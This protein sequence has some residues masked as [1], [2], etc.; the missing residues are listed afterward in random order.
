MRKVLVN[1]N[2]QIAPADK[3]GISPLDRSFLFGDGIYETGR[4]LK[5]TFVF[6][7]DHLIRFRQSAAK[8]MIPVP[9]NNEFLIHQLQ[10]TAKRFGTDDLYFR[11]ILTR[12]TIDEVGLGI[13][14]TEDPNLVIIVQEL[15]KNIAQMRQDGVTLLTS[16][17]IRNPKRAQ[18]PSIKANN[19]L[20]CLLALQEAKGRGYDDAILLNEHHHVAEGTTFSIF[21]VTDKEEILTPSLDVGILDSITRQHILRITKE[22]FN[23][24]EIATSLDVFQQC[25]EIWISSSIREVLSVKKWDQKTYPVN[26]PITQTVYALFQKH[27]TDYLQNA[28]YHY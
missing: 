20:N 9:W 26:A 21:G 28:T 22:S 8:L 7:E 15:P 24:K 3:Q 5:R 12:G 16:Q 6:L 23:T 27:L 2:G 14:P 1:V 4:A 17:I 25:S 10:E 19:H 11:I 18:D 13:F